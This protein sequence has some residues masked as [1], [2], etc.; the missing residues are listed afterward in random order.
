MIFQNKKQTEYQFAKKVKHF[1]P[2]FEFGIIGNDKPTDFL[3]I[4]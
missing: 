1:I 4:L 3:N 2:K